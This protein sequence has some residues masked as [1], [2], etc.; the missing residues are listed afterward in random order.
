[1]SNALYAPKAKPPRL[2][3]LSHP[4]P[5][6]CPPLLPYCLC[7]RSCW[8]AWKSSW[9]P[10]LSPGEAGRK[11]SQWAFSWCLGLGCAGYQAWWDLNPWTKGSCHQLSQNTFYILNLLETIEVQG[12]KE[13]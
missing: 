11:S 6:R 7:T 4:P 12:H 3:P 5:G 1:M 8:E 9:E 10:E 13:P 2:W